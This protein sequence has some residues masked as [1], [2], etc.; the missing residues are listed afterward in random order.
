[1]TRRV[2]AAVIAI[3]LGTA[4]AVAVAVP[5]A[6]A[7]RHRNGHG[8]SG[9]VVFTVDDSTHGNLE[10]VASDGKHFFTGATGDGTIYRGTL[11]GPTVHTFIPGATGRSSVGMKVKHHMLF[12][13]GGQTGIIFVYDLRH[14]DAAPLMFDTGAGGFLNDLVVTGRGVFVTDSFRPVLW[15]IASDQIKDGGMVEAIPLDPE[16]QFAGGGAF[17]VNGIVALS[18]HKLI[19]DDTDNGALFSIDV[20]RDGSRAIEMLDAPALVGADGMLIDKGRLL[21]VRGDPAGVT[22]LKGRHGHSQ[23]VIDKI[24]T[25]PSLRGPSTIARVAN[26]LVVVNADFATSTQPFTLTGLKRP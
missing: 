10:G 25:D 9:T 6:A 3:A 12:V 19:V 23:F 18:S 8:H 7:Q 17:N 24:V 11:G 15:H 2:R 4:T 5:A 14:P 16:I 20:R 1:M 13:A 21:V 22:F 26:R